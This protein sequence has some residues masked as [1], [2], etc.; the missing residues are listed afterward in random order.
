MTVLSQSMNEKE[1]VKKKQKM[2]A[3]RGVVIMFL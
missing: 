2:S 3:E 1:F